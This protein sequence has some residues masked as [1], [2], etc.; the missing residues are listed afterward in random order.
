MNSH[1]L[2][3]NACA[4]I[5]S[6]LLAGCTASGELGS[7]ETDGQTAAAARPDTTMQ[8]P[9]HRPQTPAQT[10]RQGFTTKED[11]IEVESAK[12]DHR[13]EPSALAL[14]PRTPRAQTVFAVQIG[15]FREEA[16]AARAKARLARRTK[17]PAA[18][19]FDEALK[20]Y[21]VTIGEFATQGEARRFA[22]SI[23]KKYPREYKTAWVVRITE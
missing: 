10:T 19:H 16:N 4:F 7:D 3:R 11:T 22:A 18:Q 6:A 13:P 17:R 5:V 12:H 2:L 21:R 8:A 9:A 1:T 15:A 23:R 20:L 14:Q